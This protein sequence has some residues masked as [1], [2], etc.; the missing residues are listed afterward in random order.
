[1]PAKA[2]WSADAGGIQT[3]HTATCRL[4]APGPNNCAPSP[5]G[6]EGAS[7]DKLILWC[8]R[9]IFEAVATV[10]G[11]SASRDKAQT[12]LRTIIG[13]PGRVR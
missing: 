7:T 6:D 1:M 13:L 2:Q 12:T 5:S 11:N 3:N 10:R 8:T 4:K 9:T